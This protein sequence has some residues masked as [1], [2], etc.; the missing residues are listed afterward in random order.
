MTGLFVEG[1]F[2]DLISSI[3]R[4]KKINLIVL[5]FLTSSF[6]FQ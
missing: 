5:V 2:E 4:E 6:D 3:K 1:N